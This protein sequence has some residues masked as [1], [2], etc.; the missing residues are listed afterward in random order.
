MQDRHFVIDTVL[1][2]FNLDTSNFAHPRYA[3]PISQLIY[4]VNN[5][6]NPPGY[7]V[8]PEAFL[9]DWDMEDTMNMT[10]R[11]SATDV[12]VYHSVPIFAYKDG[13]SGFDKGVSAMKRWPNR[14][15]GMY[16]AVDPLAEGAVKDLEQKIDEVESVT[17]R[18]PLGLKLYP[19]SWRGD[20]V[21]SWRMDDPKIAF[22]LYE[23]AAARGVRTVAV[24]KA[25]PLGPTP[26]GDSFHPGDVESAAATY[27]DINFEIVHG[28]AAFAE[29]TGWLL[30]RFPN[31]WVNLET[32]TTILVGR[33]R[34]F[35]LCV[36]GLLHAGG[37]PVIDRLIWSSGSMQFHPRLC[38]EAFDQFEF[39]EDLLGNFGLFGPIPQITEEHKRKIYGENFARLHGLDINAM[40]AAIANDEFSSKSDT[41]P[42]PYSTTSI[43]G[44]VQ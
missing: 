34:Q 19:T 3:E 24:H 20:A 44:K 23:A 8:P 26:A 28:G 16:A 10:F 12:G 43:A 14:L 7:T 38:R 29:E 30:G 22:P 11:E 18:P 4:A 41:L 2:A 40:K 15:V 37:E 13:L 42:A 25:I 39:P 21:D 17:G 33:P 32:L 31:I 5:A 27:P 1:H 9:R 35:A 6:A 36:L